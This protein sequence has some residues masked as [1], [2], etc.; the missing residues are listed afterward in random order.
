M[1][2]FMRQK[3]FACAGTRLILIA[4]KKDMISVGKCPRTELTAQAC[5]FGI[6]VDANI[7]EIGIKAR[8]HKVTHVTGKRLP[9]GGFAANGGL[10]GGIDRRCAVALSLYFFVFLL[11]NP[12]FG[13]LRLLNFLF[14]LLLNLFFRQLRLLDFFLFLLLNLFFRQLRLL[15]FLLFLL[16]NLFFRQLR[17]LDF[18]LFLLL[19]LFFRQL[20]LLDVFLFLL[21]NLL[22][23]HLRLL[24]FL[25]FLLL[26]LLFRHFCLLN[27]L[28]VLLLQLLL[29]LPLNF[30]FRFRCCRGGHPHHLARHLIRFLLE[31][32]PRFVHRHLHLD[33]G[34]SSSVNRC[35]KIPPACLGKKRLVR[36]LGCRP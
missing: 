36:S 26:N 6:V 18:F 19:N 32:I 4:A 35:E 9:A 21:L 31:R 33:R 14:F 8:L 12:L 3:L 5:G 22:F 28:I 27:F 15:D 7:A 30:L 16:L 34:N 25:L 13:Q 10:C 17:L 11:L 2:Q 20:G 29:F 24:N 1:A 23:R